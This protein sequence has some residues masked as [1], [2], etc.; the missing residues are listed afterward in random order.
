MKTAPTIYER[1]ICGLIFSSLIR[2]AVFSATAG[3]TPETFRKL[4][5]DVR[6]PPLSA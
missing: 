1:T 4:Q 2:L 6:K 5:H 3:L